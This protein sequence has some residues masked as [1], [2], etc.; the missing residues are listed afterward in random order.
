MTPKLLVIDDEEA[1]CRLARAIFK[2]EG[3]EVVE[4]NDGS[5][6]LRQIATEHPDIVLLDLQMPGLD[7]LQVLEKVRASDPALPVVMLT[8]SRDVKMAVKATQL[9]AHDY[10]TKPI[11]REEL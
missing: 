9:G 4:A 2:A 3:F 10:L 7:G 8:A 1:N 6:G 11:D 5:S